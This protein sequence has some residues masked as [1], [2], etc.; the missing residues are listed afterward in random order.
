MSLYNTM[1][2]LGV[3]DTFLRQQANLQSLA[4]THAIN[5]KQE[6]RDRLQ[7]EA[8]ITIGT[9]NIGDA[10]DGGSTIMRVPV[11]GGAAAGN[12]ILSNADQWATYPVTPIGG[13]VYSGT[14]WSTADTIDFCRLTS[15]RALA[16]SSEKENGSVSIATAENEIANGATF[17]YTLTVPPGVSAGHLFI[18]SSDTT[19]TF[20]FKAAK[21]ASPGASDLF[22]SSTLTDITLSA[23]REMH[24]LTALE[25]CPYIYISYTNSS[26][27]DCALVMTFNYV[28]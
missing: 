22:T 9:T 5:V 15:T 2:T 6:D 4:E 3:P 21:V 14:S 8:H 19:A 17:T 23:Q 16:V 26:G 12:T 1:A 27:S 7:V 13:V 18:Y 20:S 10:I 25:G 11:S 28:S 24:A